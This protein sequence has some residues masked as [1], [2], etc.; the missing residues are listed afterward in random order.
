M[1]Q[2]ASPSCPN[3]CAT[4]CRRRACHTS[5]AR[6]QRVPRALQRVL[7]QHRNRHR[8]DA[9]RH[10]RDEA[11]LLCSLGKVDVADQAV[12]LL[13]A[14]VVD[15]VDTHIN[16]C[17]AGLDPRPLDHLGPA[18]RSDH[19]VRLGANPLSVGRP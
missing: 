8:A 11:R 18:A 19:N 12:A 1:K 4:P 7:H 14:G 10:R 13:G 2:A 16:H 5:G 9:A 6:L 17:S 3:I 15:R